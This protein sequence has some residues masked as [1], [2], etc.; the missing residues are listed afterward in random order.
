MLAEADYFYLVS[1]NG[2]FAEIDALQFHFLAVQGY[3]L[4]QDDVVVT[5]FNTVGTRRGDGRA[6]ENQESQSRYKNALHGETSGVQLF[7]ALFYLTVAG[8][9]QARADQKTP[10]HAVAGA[11][12]AK[13]R[14]SV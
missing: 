11:E 13:P 12:S 7:A 14:D 3:D 1:R 10:L 4:A 9:T 6:K 8:T 2:H 5:E